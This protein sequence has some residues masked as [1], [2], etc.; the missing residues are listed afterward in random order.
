LSLGFKS[1]KLFSP[2]P[3]QASSDSTSSSNFQFKFL[4]YI[5][6]KGTNCFLLGFKSM[7]VLHAHKPVQIPLLHHLLIF[8]A[9]YISFWGQPCDDCIIHFL[10]ILF[11]H[12]S[13]LSISSGSCDPLGIL[14]LKQVLLLWSSSQVTIPPEPLA[15]CVSS[16]SASCY[17]SSAI[18]CPTKSAMEASNSG[19]S[20]T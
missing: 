4:S 12:S 17:S 13:R 8:R 11:Q 3:K 15:S 2:A 19:S 1:M 10:P 9:K 18:S 6:K 7:I 14:S 5:T 16:A 20:C